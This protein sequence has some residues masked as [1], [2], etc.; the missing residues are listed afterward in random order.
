MNNCGSDDSHK[1]IVK[2][3]G[4][5]NNTNEAN[6]IFEIKLPNG[7]TREADIY[8]CDKFNGCLLSNFTDNSTPTVEELN[9][10]C[11]QSGFTRDDIAQIKNLSGGDPTGDCVDKDNTPVVDLFRYYHGLPGTINYGND[12]DNVFQGIDELETSYGIEGRPSSFIFTK[13]TF[14]GGV[15]LIF[16]PLIVLFIPYIYEAYKANG[17]SLIFANPLPP[18]VQQYVGTNGQTIFHCFAIA[19][20][21]LFIIPAFVILIANGNEKEINGYIN[22]LND[23]YIT[24]DP[25]ITENISAIGTSRDPPQ[26]REQISIQTLNG[27]NL[28]HFDDTGWYN[29]FVLIGIGVFLLIYAALISRIQ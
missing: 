15:G 19:L 12:D 20:V 1:C 25:D 17:D 11:P 3:A 22:K 28:G 2:S 26:S 6:S 9:E 27:Y 8:E 24:P 4:E 21:T 13:K 14:W 23:K 18:A 5:N 29:L 16:V 7:Q 10:K